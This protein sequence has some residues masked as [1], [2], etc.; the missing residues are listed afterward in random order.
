MLVMKIFHYPPDTALSESQ[1]YVHGIFTT[2][3]D[4]TEIQNTD[5]ETLMIVTAD[6]KVLSPDKKQL[7]RIS[8]EKQGF[9]FRSVSPSMTDFTRPDLLQR[10]PEA[11]YEFERAVFG[12]YM[13]SKEAP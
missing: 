1:L 10:D 5:S 7:G 12:H 11:L 9:A 3:D 2:E 4:R 8:F 13:K 6:C